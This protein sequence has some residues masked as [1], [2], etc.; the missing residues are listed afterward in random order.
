M[1]VSIKLLLSNWFTH[2]EKNF[3]PKTIPIQKIA[4]SLRK[5]D[6]PVFQQK[7]NILVFDFW[8]NAAVHQRFGSKTGKS[9]DSFETCIW[10]ELIRQLNLLRGKE[11][12]GHH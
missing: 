8:S 6:F 1:T 10:L 7:K 5:P 9:P 11:K 3:N 4:H 12:G 2:F